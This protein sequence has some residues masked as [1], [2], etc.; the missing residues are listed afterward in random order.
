MTRSALLPAR[1]TMRVL[2]LLTCAKWIAAFV[3]VG[4]C[5]LAPPAIVATLTGGWG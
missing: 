3:I 5:A 1:D 4:A 2:L